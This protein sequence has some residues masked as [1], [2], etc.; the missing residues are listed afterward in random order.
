MVDF[1]CN[2]ESVLKLVLFVCQ[3][4]DLLLRAGGGQKRLASRL[5]VRVI[6]V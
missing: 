4:I 1:V 6:C 5:L 3:K 2:L